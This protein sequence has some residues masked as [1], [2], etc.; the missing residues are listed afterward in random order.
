M[1]QKSMYILPEPR[2]ERIAAIADM[3]TMAHAGDLTVGLVLRTRDHCGLVMMPTHEVCIDING[4]QFTVPI[5]MMR[6]LLPRLAE[7]CDA[8]DALNKK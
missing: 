7:F 3:A 2:P 8:A 6:S 1:S 4:T 5:S